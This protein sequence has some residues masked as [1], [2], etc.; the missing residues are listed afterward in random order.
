VTQLEQILRRQPDIRSLARALGLVCLRNLED[1]ERVRSRHPALE[2]E[3]QRL[4][5]AIVAVGSDW[6]SATVRDPDGFGPIVQQRGVARPMYAL[7]SVPELACH[8]ALRAICRGPLW[9]FFIA[10]GELVELRRG[11]PVPLPIRP[12]HTALGRSTPSFDTLDHDTLLAGTPFRLF[13]GPTNKSVAVVLD[14]SA[15]DRLDRVTW[16]GDETRGSFPPIAS[17]HPHGSGDDLEIGE[18]SDTTFFAVRPRYWDHDAVL[19]RL[20]SADEAR[21][22]VLPELSLAK[23]DSLADAIR[24]AHRDYPPLVVAGSAHREEPIPNASAT[25]RANVTEV[26]LDGALLLSHEKMHPF[27]TDYVGPGYS[28]KRRAEDL[29]GCRRQITIACGTHTRL[30]VL[31]CADLNDGEIPLVLEQVRANVVLVPALTGSAGAFTGAIAGLASRCQAIALI[32]NGTPLSDPS[33]P[34]PP[35]FLSM[36]ALPVPEPAAQVTEHLDPQGR[37]QITGIFDLTY[38]PP[39]VRWV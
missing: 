10:C 39:A 36:V 1:I 8:A 27:R 26:Y 23:P 12:T 29:R 30:A 14:F 35:P 13:G 25:R 2:A 15:R 17:V 18:V 19:E 33:R 38:A 20:R 9:R 34:G 37:R 21:I 28:R 7:R 11:D 22:A 24:D 3:R 16:I 31:I 4:E 32:A 5:D 6:W